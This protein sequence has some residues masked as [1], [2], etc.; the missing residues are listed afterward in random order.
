MTRDEILIELGK[1]MEGLFEIDPARL[2]LEARLAEDLGLDSIDAIDL[3]VKMQE[4][5]GRRVD[6]ASLRKI[7]TVGDVVEVIAGMM[8]PASG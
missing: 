4:L 5:T 3:A 7:R 2:R 6:E 1:Q 8:P